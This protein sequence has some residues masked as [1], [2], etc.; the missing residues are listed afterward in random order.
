MKN[1]KL[2]NYLDLKSRLDHAVEICQ[3][4]GLITLEYFYN[5]TVEYSKKNDG[6]PVTIADKKAEQLIREEIKKS[7]KA[8]SILGEEYG[9]TKGK[10]LWRWVID[11]IDG[12][13][14]FIRKVPMYGTLIGIEYQGESIGGVMFFPATNELVYGGI[15]VGVRYKD[16]KN[17]FDNIKVSNTSKL[18]DACV[19]TTTYDYFK[20]EG[21]DEA[22]KKFAD[23]CK[24]T[25]GWS[26]CYCNMLL[27]TG[28]IDA[29]IEP[30]VRPW[31]VSASIPL[32][33]EAGGS[34]TDWTGEKN[35]YPYKAIA[36]NGFIH[37]EL[38]DLL[39]PY[40]S[41]D[42]WGLIER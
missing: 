26:D 36:S 39:H 29:V 42:F 10:S 9:K 30:I 3:K 41:G 20:M 31:D 5:A 35:S 40:S 27:I 21:A 13:E 37:N 38:V 17:N 14:S 6:T 22:Y 24:M 18:A 16:R 33:L 2:W 19:C 23:K 15:G 7:W 12:T 28:R 34:Y 32:L 8:D 11:P 4:A 1:K 25:R